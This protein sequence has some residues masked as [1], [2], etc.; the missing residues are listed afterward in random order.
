MTFAE[1]YR[2]TRPKDWNGIQKCFDFILKIDPESKVIKTDLGV[3]ILFSDGS[4]HKLG[5]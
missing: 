1:H 4:Q 2:N 3:V 5:G